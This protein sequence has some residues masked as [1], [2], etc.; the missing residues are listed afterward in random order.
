M[1]GLVLSFSRAGLVRI[2]ENE[3]AY[4]L[5]RV[6]PKTKLL[7]EDTFVSIPYL[8][9]QLTERKVVIFDSILSGEQKKRKNVYE[10]VLKPLFSLL[11]IPHTYIRT[12]TSHTISDK[13]A[14]FEISLSYLAIMISGDT[15]LNELIN[16]LPR[17]I[18]LTILIIIQGTGNAFANSIGLGSV[19]DAIQS[20]FIGHLSYF[21]LYEAIFDPPGI[22][23]NEKQE[24][25]HKVDR[26]LFF[27]VGSWGLHA[28]LVA[29]SAS[30]AM[31]R[32]YGNLRFRKAAETVLKKN[33]KFIGSITLIK[34]NGERHTI[35]CNQP[36]SYF[37][38]AAMPKFE[39]TFII[40]P[41]SEPSKLELHLLYFR[42]SKASKTMELMNKAYDNGT[43]IK[44]PCVK[45]IPIND[46][47][48]VEL[49]VSD[50]ISDPACSKICLDGSIIL[51]QG[52]H[53]KIKFS[54]A[55]DKSLTYLR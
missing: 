35:E 53:R 51:L 36:L 13:A 5:E 3:T 39:P 1:G 15:S 7:S 20:L 4:T 41:D 43:H 12:N 2:D 18:D 6:D 48:S 23:L 10:G 50:S 30:I 46:G 45:Y 31:R 22:F 8:P 33:P 16:S 28:S 19:F 37:I 29:E 54:C 42:H 40:S 32:K 44:D 27:V 17:G 26:M 47:Q 24:R 11:N 14:K 52:T 49:T 34:P 25:L 21:P 9:N 55:S 38:M